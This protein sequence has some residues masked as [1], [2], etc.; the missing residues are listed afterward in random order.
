MSKKILDTPIE[1]FTRKLFSNIIERLAVISNDKNLTF[2]QM[3][4]LHVIDREK[5]ININSLAELLNLSTSATS[6][7]INDLVEKDF[8]QRIEDP[9]NRR[10]KIL[11]LSEKGIEFMDKLSIERVNHIKLTIEK[12]TLNVPQKFLSFIKGFF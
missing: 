2:S 8:I 1:I 7:L 6:R 4:A 11:S 3:A 9:E 5:K 10:S 12:T